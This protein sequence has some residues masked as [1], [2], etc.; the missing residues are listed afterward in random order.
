MAAP[1]LLGTTARHHPLIAYIFVP[2]ARG[3]RC[4]VAAL[5]SFAADSNTS[6]VRIFAKDINR[7]GQH[8]WR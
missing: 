5:N 6:V 3:K 4:P 2:K 8:Y 1:S 7:Y